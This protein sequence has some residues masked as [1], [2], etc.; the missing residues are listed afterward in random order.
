[1]RG[2]WQCEF[3]VGLAEIDGGA[4]LDDQ[5]RLLSAK[6]YRP[7]NLFV[8]C[9]FLMGIVGQRALPQCNC[10]SRRLR[11]LVR[12]RNPSRTPRRGFRKYLPPRRR[13]C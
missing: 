7:V 3:T 1:M 8:R 12:I 9:C 4:L 6:I 11:I 10:A 5:L 13:L 2:S